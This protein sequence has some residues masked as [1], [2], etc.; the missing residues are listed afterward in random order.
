MRAFLSSAALLIGGLTSSLAQPYVADGRA[1]LPPSALTTASPEEPPAFYLRA[2]QGALAAGRTREAQEALE[3][4]Q[5]R[6]LDRA[7][8]M[9]QTNDPSDNPTVGQ[10]SQALRALAARD[11]ATCL[12][13]IQA[14]IQSATAQEFNASRR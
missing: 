2:A 6:M 10:I 4:A 8:P 3:M 13:L 12:G 14:A 1:T 5:T 11:R 7:V 9:G